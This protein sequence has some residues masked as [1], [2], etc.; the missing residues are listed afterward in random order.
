[1]HVKNMDESAIAYQYGIFARKAMVITNLPI[2]LA[3]AAAS[4]M[5]PEVSTTFARGDR[6][7][8]GITVS[9]VTRVILMI[10]IPCAVGLFALARPVM[11]ILFPQ[12]ASLAEASMLLRFLSVTVVLYS[13]STV[14]NAV[15]QGIGKVNA[16]VANALF[17]LILQSVVL[18]LLLVFT[19]LGDVALCIV[20]IIYSL[21]MC[22]LNNMVMKQNL[23]IVNDFKKTYL[24]PVISSVIM[25]AGAYGVYRLFAYALSFAIQSDYFVNIFATTLAAGAG[26]CIYFVVLIKSGGAT[27]E[28]IMR[29]PK[30]ASIVGIL[31]K[32][33]IL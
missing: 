18:T 5:I 13:L 28:D 31:K 7:E 15:L 22:V 16:P 4:A 10:S 11:M 2:A 20:T 24:L 8:A 14:T 17:A 29:F 33:R 19:D 3:S 6:E 9:R 27:Q 12:K 1:M 21:V 30:G 26:V 32:A 25:G 23:T